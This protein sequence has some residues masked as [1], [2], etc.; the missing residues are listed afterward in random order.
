MENL[1]ACPICEMPDFRAVQACNDYT[2]SRETFTISECTGCGFWFTNPR[3]GKEEIGRYY[4]SEE[5]ISHS[6]KTKGFVGWAYRQVREFTLKRK[7]SLVQKLV[8]ERGSRILD[9]GCG[10]GEFLNA[11]K[12]RGYAV[13]GVEPSD[14]A[15][16]FSIKE[17]GLDVKEEDSIRG[18]SPQCFSLITMWHVLEHVH[19]L[20]ER[21]GEIRRLLKADG[22]CLVAVPNRL[23]WDAIKY[24]SDWAAYDLP[25]HLY[26]FRRKDI[27]RL[28]G[29]EGF[30]LEE[31]LPMVFDSYY[32][33]MLSDKHR[34]S[35]NL[36]RSTWNGFVSNMKASTTE[37]T[38]SS[39][40]YILRKRS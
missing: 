34:G 25:R 22:V 18:L 8:P 31:T 4:E 24:G 36:I 14:R 7:T 39:Q 30:V 32:V 20:K 2:V 5:Y 12:A 11:C 29:G 16:D 26:H 28:F 37:G 6:G 13:F 38:W 3:P 27:E 23:S 15:R 19:Q 40:I 9:I 35:G 33:S 10:T 1:I 17:Y 21:V